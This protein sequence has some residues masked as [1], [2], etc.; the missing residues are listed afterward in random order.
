MRDE[1]G[2]RIREEYALAFQR[3]AE[4]DVLT[5]SEFEEIFEDRDPTEFI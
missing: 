5:F 3:M 4:G 2:D 1:Q